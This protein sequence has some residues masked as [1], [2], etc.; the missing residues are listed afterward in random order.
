MFNMFTISSITMFSGG[1]A[2]LAGAGEGPEIEAEMDEVREGQATIPHRM[3]Q[4][5]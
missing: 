1:R 5:T 4:I 2:E 3:L